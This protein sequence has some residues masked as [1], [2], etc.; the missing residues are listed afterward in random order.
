MRRDGKRSGERAE[1]VRGRPFRR[2]AKIVAEA[3][4]APLALLRRVLKALRDLLKPVGVVVGKRRERNAVV[5]GEPFGLRAPMLEFLGS[6]DVGLRRCR[7]W[8]WRKASSLPAPRPSAAA[9]TRSRTARS[10][11][12]APSAFHSPYFPLATSPCRYYI[13]AHLSQHIAAATAT[14]HLQT[15]ILR[16]V[17]HSP[18]NFLDSG[19][20][21]ASP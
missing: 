9:R 5:S 4:R 3:P 1:P 17:N 8:S 15:L 6:V 14:G 7:C 10:R 20:R 18:S 21:L 11:H 12:G 16:A 2:L 13:T 19:T